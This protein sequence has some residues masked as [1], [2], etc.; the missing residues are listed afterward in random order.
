M[1]SPGVG[2]GNGGSLEGRGKTTKGAKITKRLAFVIFVS[3]VVLPL[4]ESR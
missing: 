3:S 4:Q 2:R 1:A